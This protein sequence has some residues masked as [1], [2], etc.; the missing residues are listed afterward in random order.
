MAAVDDRAAG[1]P[2]APGAAEAPVAPAAVIVCAYSLE[3]WPLLRAA[4]RAV[5][6]QEPAAQEVIVVVDGNRELYERVTASG[7]ADRVLM[8]RHGG[9]A[10]GGRMTGAE[11]TD[12]PLLVFLDDDA[13]PEPD[14]LRE[15]LRPYGDSAGRFERDGEPGGRRFVAHPAPGAASATHPGASAAAATDEAQGRS[16][17][18]VLGT[19]GRLDAMWETARPA[20]LPPEYDWVVGCSFDGAHPEPVPV[21]NPIAASMSIRADVFASVGGMALELGRSDVGG[22]VSG[23]AEETELAIRASRRHPGGVWIHAPHARARHHVPARRAT[24]RYFRERCAL[25]GRAKAVLTR[26]SGTESGLASE[27]DYVRRALPRALARE[28]AAGLRGDPD[29]WRRAGTVLAG[30]AFTASAYAARWL[31]LRVRGPSPRA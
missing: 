15:L 24:W 21:R 16:A 3:R 2:V 9:G 19:G 31:E 25:E 26:L 14:W 29:G 7:L 13:I 1:A 28:L 23:T 17:P 18:L 4:L 12:A 8:N 20:W 10:A 6:A 22:R 27:R 11:A 30:L 5:A